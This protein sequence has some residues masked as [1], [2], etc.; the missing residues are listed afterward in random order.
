MCVCVCV[1]VCV[2]MYLCVFVRCVCL[3][4]LSISIPVEGWISRVLTNPESMTYLMP[5]IVTDVSAIFV[6]RT[7]FLIPGG[8]GAK[9][10]NYGS[11]IISL[12]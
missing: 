10:R 2:C 9:A 4:T 8:E 7:N 5:E 12:N 3:V 6:D 1:C 11:E